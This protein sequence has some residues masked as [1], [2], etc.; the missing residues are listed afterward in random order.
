MKQN[1][2]KQIQVEEIQRTTIK[3]L[4][5]TCG[6]LFFSKYLHYPKGRNMVCG[7]EMLL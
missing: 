3:V 6:V 5:S 7:A 4:K 2:P 1:K